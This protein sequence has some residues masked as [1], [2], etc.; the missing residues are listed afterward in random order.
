MDLSIIIVN[1]NAR[2]LLKDCLNSIFSQKGGEFEVWVVDNASSD[3]SV[4]M[5][6]K[7][8]PQVKLIKNRENLGFA[9]ANNLAFKKAQ[10][11]FL[12]LLNPDTIIKDQTLAKVVNFM[13]EN[14]QVGVCGVKIFNPDGSFQPSVG[15]FYNLFNAFLM[16]FGGEKLGFLRS[17]PVQIKEVDWASGAALMVRKEVLDKAGFFDE[18]FFMYMEEVEWCFRIKKAGFKIIFYPETEITHYVRRSGTK[19]EAIWGIYKGLIYFYQKHKPF[20]QLTILKALL[21]TKA[22]LAWILGVIAKNDY[23]R[24]TYGKA[25]RLA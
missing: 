23:L 3:G 7:D 10:G 4:E 11:R 13:R 22:L 21:K 1:F 16:L 9:R 19:S 5:V 18:N 14:P 12:F 24:T 8:F 25:F 2:Q 6:E 17:S 15:K 20:W